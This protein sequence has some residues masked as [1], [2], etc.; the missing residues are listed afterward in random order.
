MISWSKIS[1]LT[2][3]QTVENLIDISGLDAK[4]TKEIKE[5]EQEIRNLPSEKQDIVKKFIEKELLN[6]LKFLLDFNERIKIHKDVKDEFFLELKKHSDDVVQKGENL[7]KNIDNKLFEKRI[8]YFFRMLISPWPYK[9][10]IMDKGFKKYR[11]YPG[12]YEM[13]DYVYNNKICS[14]NIF[15]QY[16]DV[17]F[18]R[19]AYSEA[20]RGRKNLMRDILLE[21]IGQQNELRILN[22]P[23]GPSRDVQEFLETKQSNNSF[24]IIC[25]DNDSESL[26]FAQ[27]AIFGL[28]KS[29]NVSFRQGNILDYSRNPTKAEKDLGTFDII[30]SIGIADYF[31]DKLLQK[32]I[33]STYA[34]IKPGGELIFAFKITNKDPFAPLPPKWFCD[35]VFVPR[36]LE[37]SI[38]VVEESGIKAFTKTK[39][40][41]EESGR[42]CF[43]EYK[44]G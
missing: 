18:I 3:R 9:S 2:R 23:C 35:W 42:I 25:V 38:K 17:Y 22:I 1:N 36:S 43:L 13:M 31:P 11:G 39:E 24:E 40:I 10:I 12:D 21:E 29:E 28:K 27:K 16:F 5:F 20:V 19:N 30:Y 41:W 15:G 4:I 8:R 44:K 37:E 6:Y 32:F 26:E 7:T 33:Y 14:N 34:M